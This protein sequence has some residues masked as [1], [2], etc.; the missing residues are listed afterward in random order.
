[1]S[2]PIPLLDLH[3]QHEPILPELRDAMDRVVRS[4][5]FIL[6]PEVSSLEA[7]LADYLDVPH[8]LGVSSGTDALLVALMGLDIGPGDEVVTTPYTFFSTGGCVS[9]LGARPVFVDIDPRTYNLD[10]SRLETAIGARTKAIMVVHLFGQSCEMPAVRAVA[11]THGLPIIEDAAQAIGVRTPEGTIGSLGRVGCFSFFPSKNLG[12]FGDGGLVTTTDADLAEKMRVLRAHGAKP[13]Y[14]HS[15]IGGNFR[16]DAIQAAV[17]RVKLPHL[18]GWSAARRENADRYT[19]LFSARGLPRDVLATPERVYDGHIY[20][21][22]VI[23]V[24]RRDELRQHLREHQIGCEVYYPRPL[25]LQECFSDL[26]YP[27]GSLPEAE[28][29]A[30]ET[31]AI[32]VYPEVGEARQRRVVDTVCQFLAP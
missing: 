19:E 31:L 23:R 1:M 2:E 26:G 6:G 13:K 7:E 16:L 10:P 12:A 32:P 20:N 3:A 21:Q 11:E 29:A 30:K 14:F 17:L 15:L 22:Y 5:R 4:G 24:K 18:D 28:A 9:R 8:A 27:E 25:H